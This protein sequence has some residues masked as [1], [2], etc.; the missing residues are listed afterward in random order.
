ML[1]GREHVIFRNI[2][3]KLSTN[4]PLSAG[5]KKKKS[6]N[7]AWRTSW[8][9][10]HR[11]GWKKNKIIPLIIHDNDVKWLAPL[12]TTPCGPSG[13]CHSCQA[14]PFTAL[15]FS[16]GTGCTSINQSAWGG[17]LSVSR[18]HSALFNF[19]LISWCIFNLKLLIR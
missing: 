5:K 13:W 2:A 10:I 8:E 7:R 3:A 19:Y 18:L 12:Q 14:D 6:Q 15:C 9:L 1:P 11:P 4:L 17:R 16:P